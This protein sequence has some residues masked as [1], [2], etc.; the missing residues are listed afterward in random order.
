[1]ELYTFELTLLIDVVTCAGAGSGLS[2]QDN[3]AFD[4]MTTTT[5]VIQAPNPGNHYAPANSLL[6]GSVKD[7][8]SGQAALALNECGFPID[9]SP[10]DYMMEGGN[11]VLW[12][13]VLGGEFPWDERYY[14][15]NPDTSDGFDPEF[16]MMHATDSAS[17]A[18][19]MATGH[20]AAVNM[21]SQTLYEEDV[22]TLVEDAMMCGKAGGVVTSVPMF[23]ATPGAF[24]IHTNY[25]SDR[26]SLR[27][28]FEKV[29][30]TYAGGVC[31]SRYY[32]FP[33]TLESMRS[34]AL[35]SQWTLLEQKNTTM[36]EVRSASRLFRYIENLM[37]NN[38][39]MYSFLLNHAGLLCW[40]GIH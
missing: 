23:H 26:D 33:E 21:M 36:K 2:F 8:K 12:D 11:M 14:Q 32:P 34:G 3:L 28:S 22:S 7:H 24:I 30:P 5:T 4:L 25:R 6:E 16:I 17:T 10:K 37:D 15:E 35:S 19:C 39:L 13:D 18:G 20:K 9:F 40:R 29:N 31:G 27:R 38:S 1:M